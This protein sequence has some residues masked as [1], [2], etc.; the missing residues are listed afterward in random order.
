MIASAAI[1]AMDSARRYMVKCH[2]EDQPSSQRLITDFFS[3][4]HSSANPSVRLTPLSRASHF[5]VFRLWTLVRDFADLNPRIP[6][7]WQ[8]LDKLHGHPILLS[9]D[10]QTLV[11]EPP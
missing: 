2:L 6:S 4:A 10:G 5:A 8:A 1:A 9:I 3:H 7:H 11:Y